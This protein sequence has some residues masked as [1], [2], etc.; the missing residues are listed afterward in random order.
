MM[1]LCGGT[2]STSSA[3]AVAANAVDALR[4]RT[5]RQTVGLMRRAGNFGLAGSA[6]VTAGAAGR[7]SVDASMADIADVAASGALLTSS[8]CAE[9]GTSGGFS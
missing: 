6:D 1:G 8:T 7:V 5:G 9:A 4:L 2:E 3:A